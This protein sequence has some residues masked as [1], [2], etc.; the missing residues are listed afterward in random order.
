MTGHI[1]RE[2]QLDATL[3]AAA[4]LDER[5][6][7]RA[8]RGEGPKRGD[9]FL[10]RR[11]ADFPVQWLVLDTVDERVEVVPVD[12]HPYAGSRDL[13]LPTPTLGGDAVVRCDLDAW[14]DAAELEP[15]LRTATLTQLEVERVRRKRRA[16]V[17]GEHEPTLLEEEVDGDPEYLH[18]REHTLDR[19]LWALTH[20]SGDDVPV[21]PDVAPRRRWWPL[22]AAAAVLL[23]LAFGWQQ[24]RLSQQLEQGKAH[25]ARLEEVRETL[26]E[27]LASAETGR[28]ASVDEAGRLQTVL[29]EAAEAAE[30]ALAEQEERFEGRLRRAFDRSVV[31]NVPSFVLGKLARTRAIQ[32]QPEVITP[33]DAA[34]MTL[35]LEVPDPEPYPHYRLRVVDKDG[36]D[37]VWSTDALAKVSGKWLR[38]DLPVDL[39]EAGEYELLLYGLGAAGAVTLDERYAIRLER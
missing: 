21:D 32:G 26:A 37:E 10:T 25:I 6:T 39:L 9:V 38:L 15:E 18:W 30:Q 11:T 2:R 29:R 8:P 24:V 33:G 1:P 12:E 14:T 23:T 17:T 7:T 13:E 4:E 22:L 3:A 35:S 19:A 5:Q 20:E 36:G 28:E 34:R 27:Q 16:V 31:V